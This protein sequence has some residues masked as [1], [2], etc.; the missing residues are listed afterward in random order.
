MPK[1]KKRIMAGSFSRLDV[2]EQ[3]ALHA[4]FKYIDKIPEP[5][6]GTP[7]RGLTEWPNDRG[8]RIHDEV[9]RYIRGKLDTISD[10]GAF[11]FKDWKKLFNELRKKFKQGVVLPEEMW[12]FTKEWKNCEADDW[13]HIYYRVKT[14]VTAFLTPEEAVVI[15]FKTG[16]IRGNEIK[17]NQQCQSYAVGAFIRFPSLLKV[18]TELWYFDHPKEDLFP[19]VYSR[20]QGIRLHKPLITRMDAMTSETAFKPNPNKFSCRWCPYRQDRSGDC[21]VGVI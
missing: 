19:T 20:K 12:C 17:Y 10:S 18:T 5:D 16:R 6:R 4:K 3:C 21:K 9:D 15:D 11:I 1:Q 8:S 7:P 2:Y 13:N 14:D